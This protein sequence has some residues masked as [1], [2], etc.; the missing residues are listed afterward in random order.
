VTEEPYEYATLR[1]EEA[2]EAA[3][4]LKQELERDVDDFRA[5][6]EQRG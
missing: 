4:R 5:Q 6:G 2:T 3:N 1:S